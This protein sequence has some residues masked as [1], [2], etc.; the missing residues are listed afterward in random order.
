[1]STMPKMLAVGLVLLL[2]LL[3]ASALAAS[4]MF[5]DHFDAGLGSHP[6]V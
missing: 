4:S 5:I 3:T 1:M 6:R 2:T